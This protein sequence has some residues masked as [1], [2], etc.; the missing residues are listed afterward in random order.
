MGIGKM[1]T[2]GSW[3]VNDTGIYYPSA[4]IQVDHE[5]LHGADSGRTEDGVMHITWVRRDVPKIF[6]RWDYLTGREVAY[7]KD[8]IQG[9]EFTLHYFD[10]GEKK[11]VDVY[12]SKL[13]YKQV[14]N[15][16]YANEGGL[17]KD[18]AASAITR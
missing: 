15:G 9:K 4:E 5:S 12:V 16:A 10:M 17:Y 18:I 13:T 2:D 14:H 11:Q 3:A 6:L 1:C 8:L 7:I